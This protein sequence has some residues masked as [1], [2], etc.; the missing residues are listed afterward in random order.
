MEEREES[1]II[2]V[3]K[4]FGETSERQVRMLTFTR[5]AKAPVHRF[6]LV[7]L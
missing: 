5:K 1:A 3:E 2:M 6:M 4:V 7:N